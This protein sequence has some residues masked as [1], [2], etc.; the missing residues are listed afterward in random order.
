MSVVNKG[1]L[2]VMEPHLTEARGTWV[3]SPLPPL[4]IS[5]LPRLP[6]RWEDGGVC[7]GG[8]REVSA[9]LWT[10]SS[11]SHDVDDDSHA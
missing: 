6:G 8:E 4:G 5:A 7:V 11:Y 2:G 10:C 1:R 3:G 9:K